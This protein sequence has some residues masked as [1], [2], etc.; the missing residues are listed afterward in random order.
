LA[1]RLPGGGWAAKQSAGGD[2]CVL[3]DFAWAQL[4]PAALAGLL[5]TIT[6]FSGGR[7]RSG[8]R[9]AQDVV[10]AAP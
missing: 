1:A 3:A 5:E 6:V 7:K 2:L 8:V 4:T 10:R 9:D